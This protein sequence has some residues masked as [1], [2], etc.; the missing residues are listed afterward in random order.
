M[1]RP[2]LGA[3]YWF[4][5]YIYAN[6]GLGNRGAGNRGFD[7]FKLLLGRDE[8]L[9]S[10]QDPGEG[11]RQFRARKFHRLNPQTQEVFTTQGG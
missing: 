6:D 11:A 2:T 8:K 3:T 10:G 4:N 7:V 5:D 9:P 1:A